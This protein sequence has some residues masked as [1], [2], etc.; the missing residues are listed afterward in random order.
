MPAAP[1]LS[2]A[3]VLTDTVPETMPATG[4]TMAM[5]G[6]VVSLVTVVAA[7]E[8]LTVTG[9]DAPLFPAASYAYATNVADPFTTPVESQLNEYGDALAVA[10]TVPLTVSCTLAT[11][12]LSLADMLTGTIPETVLL[13]VGEEMVAV[14][15]MV[16]A[17]VVAAA[18]A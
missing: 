4:L 9:V 2:L 16:S 15:A 8:T 14:G 10:T 18:A 6:G 12:T 3:L 1:L 11:P 13:P 5:I 7:F 17:G